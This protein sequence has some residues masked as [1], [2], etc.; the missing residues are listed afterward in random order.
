[1]EQPQEDLN[2]LRV[3]ELFQLWIRDA[4]AISARRHHQ[5]LVMRAIRRQMTWE[6]LNNV[7]RPAMYLL[8]LEGLGLAAEWNALVRARETP[9]YRRTAEDWAL[10][11]SRRYRYLKDRVN[12]WVDRFYSGF[13]AAGQALEEEEQELVTP[14]VTEETE[15]T[16]ETEATEVTRLT[17][18]SEF[19]EE[20]GETEETEETEEVPS[21]GEQEQQVVGVE[22]LLTPISVPGTPVHD[23]HG[24]LRS[25][26]SSDRQRPKRQATEA[27][28]YGF[29]AEDVGTP[30]RAT[31]PRLSL[32]DFLSVYDELDFTPADVNRVED[33]LEEICDIL[34]RHHETPEEANREWA[35]EIVH[36]R[37]QLPVRALFFRWDLKEGIEPMDKSEMFPGLI[38]DPITGQ[39]PRG[40]LSVV[41]PNWQPPEFNPFELTLE[42]FV[43]ISEKQAAARSVAPPSHQ[44]SRT[45]TST[46]SSGGRQGVFAAPPGRPSG[47]S[48]AAGLPARQSSSSSSS[49]A[50]V[51]ST[52]TQTPQVG[53]SS[54]S[55]SGPPT[56]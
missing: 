34:Y 48:A 50:Q 20:T 36:T 25:T 38:P 3:A 43:A 12:G 56:W 1:M 5:T 9:D 30:P 28:H 8:V 40:A 22:G 26:A 47:S 33:L 42:Q 19:A 23:V 52:S 49:S 55:Q 15:V 21:E 17:Q 10:V 51:P 54:S 44:Y 2:N 13:E 27:K 32:N 41:D 11:R 14:E 24:T 35:V 6:D 7:G 45:S 53:L 16:G 18:D 39:M 4:R 37:S 29:A 46:S 31:G